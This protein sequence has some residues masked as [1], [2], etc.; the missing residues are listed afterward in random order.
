MQKVEI[1]FGSVFALA[2]KAADKA[3]HESKPVPMAVQS[4]GLGESFDW[5]KPHEIVPD[6]VCGFAWVNIHGDGRS[7]QIKE[8]KPFGVRQ[9]YYGGWQFSSTSASPESRYSQSMQRM[10][11]ACEAFAKVLGEYGY[12]ASVG[13]RMD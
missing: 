4:S 5:N 8:M 7:K 6:G 13:S 1:S 10:E 9:N 3:F 11:A 12:K 2:Q